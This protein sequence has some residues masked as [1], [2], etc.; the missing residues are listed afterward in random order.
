LFEGDGP[1][2]ESGQA[3]E[4]GKDEGGAESA[5]RVLLSR[6]HLMMRSRLKSFR[7]AGHF[8]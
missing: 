5:H 3:E 4:E 1:R 2:R 8:L 6:S 7:A